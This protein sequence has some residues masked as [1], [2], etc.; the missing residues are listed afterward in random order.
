V[1][2]YDNNVESFRRKVA[3]DLLYLQNCS[4]WNDFKIL[5]R[6]VGVV[7]TGKGAL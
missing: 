6:T 7:I 4:V 5:A 3:F 2:G 1:N